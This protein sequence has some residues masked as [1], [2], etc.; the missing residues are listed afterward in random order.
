MERAIKNELAIV[1]EKLK[2]NSLLIIERLF[3][4]R[5]RKTLLDALEKI[6]FN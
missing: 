1:N 2:S 5:R 3:F 6:I 4:E